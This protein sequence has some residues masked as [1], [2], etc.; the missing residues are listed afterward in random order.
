MQMVEPGI[1]ELCC[2]A[3]IVRSG[4]GSIFYLCRLSFT[5]PQFP[6]YPRLP[7]TECPGYARG[8]PQAPKAPPDFLTR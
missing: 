1:C 5:W 3:Q 8:E 4:R 7:V 6:K 2:H